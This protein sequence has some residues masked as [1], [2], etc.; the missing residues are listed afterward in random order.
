MLTHKT[1]HFFTHW[2]NFAKLFYYVLYTVHAR[3]KFGTDF[4]L[5][6]TKIR[7]FWFSIV[8]QLHINQANTTF[9]KL[10]LITTHTLFM[11]PSLFAN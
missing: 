3:S 1:L 10:T 8:L 4:A 2:R 9:H 5:S 6:D 7:P 11:I